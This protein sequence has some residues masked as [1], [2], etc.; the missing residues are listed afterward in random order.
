MTDHPITPLPELVAQIRSDALRK[1][2]DVLDYELRMI[3]AAYRA[4]ADQELEACCE[5]LE[6][7]GYSLTVSKLRAARRP[8]PPNLAEQA[9]TLINKIQGNQKPWQLN[10]LDVVRTAL[11]RLQ[12]LENND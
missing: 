3:H 4:G 12:E 8:K 5:W 11:E 7:E 2:S 6:G 10:E 1:S 9:L